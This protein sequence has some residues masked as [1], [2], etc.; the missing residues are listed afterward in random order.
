MSCSPGASASIGDGTGGARVTRRIGPLARALLAAAAVALCG[1]CATFWGFSQALSGRPPF[2]EDSRE[3]A[4]PLPGVTEQLGVVLHLEGKPLPP[5]ATGTTAAPKTTAVP[6]PRD[7]EVE[8]VVAQTGRE[9]VYRAATYYGRTWKWMTGISFL[10]EGALGALYLIAGDRTT[11]YVYG[12][13]FAADALVTGIL[14]FAPRRHTYDRSERKRSVRVRSDCPAGLLLEIAG[15]PVPVDADGQL[16]PLTLALLERHITTVPEPIRVR[17]GPYAGELTLDPALRC[18]WARRRSLPAA[19]ELCKMAG[20]S[21]SSTRPDRAS[22]PLVL[23]VPLGLLT[24]PPETPA[25][26]TGP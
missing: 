12:G 20:A 16:S 22:L 15:R 9:Q 5:A 18:E 17:L 14:F 11:H 21:E 8:C 25:E 23:D 10:I 6:A 24:A 2:E 26:A 7:P 1:G 19:T 3:Q 13:Y 4:V